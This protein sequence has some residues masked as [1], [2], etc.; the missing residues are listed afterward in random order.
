MKLTNSQPEPILT[1][2]PASWD[3]WKRYEIP[4]N[5]HHME[6]IMAN[7]SMPSAPPGPTTDLNSVL[8]DRGDRY[9]QFTGHAKVTQDFKGLLAMH[10]K[11][12]S[13]NLSDDQQEALDMIFHKIGRIVNGDANYADSWIDIAGYAKLVS[14]RLEGTVR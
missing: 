11:A 12:R 10:L 14:D 13:K 2:D 8:D 5:P 7:H 3:A 9:G 1:A 6:D 4:F